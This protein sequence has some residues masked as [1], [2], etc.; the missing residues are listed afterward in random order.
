[1]LPCPLCIIPETNQRVCATL[2][3]LST[4]QDSHKQITKDVSFI[5][6]YY[7][8]DPVSF[9]STPLTKAVILNSTPPIYAD[10]AFHILCR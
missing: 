9:Y 10:Y 6:W 2:S 7:Y 3:T 1:M 8:N 4:G 5:L